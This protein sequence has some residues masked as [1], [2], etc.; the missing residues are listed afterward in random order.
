MINSAKAFSS[1]SV[2]NI[3]KEKVAPA[4][5][6]EV[7]NE[8][9]LFIHIEDAYNDFKREPKDGYSIATQ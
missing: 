2:D 9:P 8:K 1:F 6:T 4:L 3:E 7:I 5:F